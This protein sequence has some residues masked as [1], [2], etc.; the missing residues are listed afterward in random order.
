MNGT[1]RKRPERSAMLFRA[2]SK[3]AI[4]NQIP[5]RKRTLRL[6]PAKSAGLRSG[7]W[8]FFVVYR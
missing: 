3:D 2:Q 8:L 6:R 1:S 7:C 4:P 5:L